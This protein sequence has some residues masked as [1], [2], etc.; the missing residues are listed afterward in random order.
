MAET[1]SERLNREMA[2]RHFRQQRA[3]LNRQQTI[4]DDRAR[5]Y[6]RGR[7]NAAFNATLASNARPLQPRKPTVS[8]PIDPHHSGGSRSSG[9]GIGSVV[10]VALAILCVYAVAHSVSLVAIGEIAILGILAVT[11]VAIL[12]AV[13]T[14]IRNHF[15]GIG[16]AA[17]AAIYAWVHFFGYPG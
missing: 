13:L 17:G 7:E 14:F 16:V 2:E 4:M 10:G 9:I 1:T 8:G 3:D 12:V 6:R 11:A 5:E 15:F